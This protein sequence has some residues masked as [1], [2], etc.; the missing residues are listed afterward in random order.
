[1]IE[2]FNFSKGIIFFF[3]NVVMLVCDN[4]KCLKENISGNKF[5]LCGLVF[6]Y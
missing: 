6:S 2:L 3:V 5:F 4:V 1:M